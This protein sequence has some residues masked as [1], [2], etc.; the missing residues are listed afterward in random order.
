MSWANVFF[1]GAKFNL[2]Y[3]VLYLGTGGLKKKIKLES[4]VE[5]KWIMLRKF[6]SYHGVD[7]EKY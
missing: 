4:S 5:R 2:K 6:Q 7:L 1:L 3:L